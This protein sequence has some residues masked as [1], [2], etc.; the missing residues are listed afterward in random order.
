METRT[1]QRAT[2]ITELRLTRAADNKRQND[3]IAVLGY[4]P[5]ALGD[6]Q[7]ISISINSDSSQGFGLYVPPGWK[8]MAGQGGQ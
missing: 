1:L 2:A 4:G 7:E 8:L 3:A 5:V 6:A